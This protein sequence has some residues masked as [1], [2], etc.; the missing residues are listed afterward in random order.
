MCFGWSTYMPLLAERVNA[1]C[2]G[3]KHPAPP[4]AMN[5]TQ[6]KGSSGKRQVAQCKKEKEDGVSSILF[7]LGP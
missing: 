6:R 3:Y 7:K 1:G 5:L 4:G 2:D